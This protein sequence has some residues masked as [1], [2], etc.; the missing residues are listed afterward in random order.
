MRYRESWEAW[1][2]F[3]EQQGLW[4]QNSNPNAE[5]SDGN[6]AAAIGTPTN[7]WNAMG[8]TPDQIQYRPW[9]TEVPTYRCPSD[10]GIGLPALGRTNYAA[11]LGDSM[12][13]MELGFKDVRRRDPTNNTSRN[14]RAACRGIFV[15]ANHAKFRDILDG[16]SNTIAMGEIITALQDGDKR[17]NGVANNGGNSGPFGHAAL[18]NNPSLCTDNGYIDPERPLFYLPQWQQQNRRNFARGHRWADCLP[19]MST[20]LIVLPPNREA[21][22][23]Y[24]ALGTRLVATVSSRHQ[25]GAHVLMGDGAVIFMTDSVEAGDSRAPMV[26]HNGTGDN[27]P[28]AKSPYGLWGALGTRANSETIEEQLNQ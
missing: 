17:G 11:C 20:V 24:N 3:M 1:L 23:R 28:G 19:I 25:G 9:V 6:T 18:R 26:W 15:T 16:L 5:R 22:G 10:P 7:P 13:Q 12:W 2:P 27:A 21:C 4:S 8:P 14:G